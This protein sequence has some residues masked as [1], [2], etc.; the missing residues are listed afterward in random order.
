MAGR[1]K[2]A[3]LWSTSLVGPEKYNLSVEQGV[4]TKHCAEE[5]FSQ[6]AKASKLAS[7]LFPDS[8]LAN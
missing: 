2:S 6:L 4:S 3:A 8:L 7:Y 5:D 1:L